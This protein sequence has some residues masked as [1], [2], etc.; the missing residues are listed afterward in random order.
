MEGKDFMKM[1]PQ[2]TQDE[3]NEEEEQMIYAA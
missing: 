3:L 2:K 1:N